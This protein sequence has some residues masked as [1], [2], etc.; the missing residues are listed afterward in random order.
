MT[1]TGDTGKPVTW[2]TIVAKAV[3]D[4]RQSRRTADTE[5]VDPAPPRD[6]N[7]VPRVAAGPR[8]A[9]ELPPLDM[10]AFIRSRR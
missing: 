7:R 8:G 5:A 6:P 10:N 4:S 1:A 3:R 9:I 2:G